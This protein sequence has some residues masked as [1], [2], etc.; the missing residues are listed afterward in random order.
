MG[1]MSCIAI[2]CWRKNMVISSLLKYD[3]FS[4]D[5]LT[6]GKIALI[7][8]SDTF[9]RLTGISDYSLLMA[10]TANDV[11]EDEIDAISNIVDEKYT[12]RDKRAYNFLF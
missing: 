8:S 3:L 7:T 4:S 11:S 5:R 12:F 9:T 10:Q 6:N 1:T 2:F